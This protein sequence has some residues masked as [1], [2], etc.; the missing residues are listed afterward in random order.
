MACIA[1]SIPRR[2]RHFIT[3]KVEKEIVMVKPSDVSDSCIESERSSL[4]ERSV[5]RCLLSQ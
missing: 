2:K 1:I 5:K 4:E 3:R